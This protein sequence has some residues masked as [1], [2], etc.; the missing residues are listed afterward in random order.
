MTALSGTKKLTPVMRQYD[1]AKTAHPDAIIFFRLGDFYEVFHEDAVVVSKALNITLTS[2]DKGENPTPMAGVPHHAAHGY[3]ARLLALGHKVAL[4]EQMADPSKVKGIVPRQVTRVVTPSLITESDQLDPRQ[5]C[6]LAAIDALASDPSHLSLALLDLSTG[7]LSVALVQDTAALAAEIARADPREVLVPE[8]LDALRATLAIVAP[9][10]A[11]RVDPL[12][13]DL[14]V[15]ETIDASV[16]EPLGARTIAEHGLGPA[17][18]A[19]RA[20]RYAHHCTPSAPV[21]VR[22]VT[23]YDPSGTLRIDETAQAHLELVRASDGGREGSL[24]G[25][26]FVVACSRRSS[27]CARFDAASMRSSAS[28]RT[29]APAPSCA[30]RSA[31]SVISSGSRCAR[32]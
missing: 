20:L 19:A 9:R 30:T 28:S 17:R 27:T 5:S 23:A 1:E 16:P 8:A 21:P 13:A 12:L 6:Y 18:A 29:R 25:V 15:T 10:A 14:D 3:I 26:C 7:E 32:S 11:M 31:P 24:L 2:R 22:R 4:C